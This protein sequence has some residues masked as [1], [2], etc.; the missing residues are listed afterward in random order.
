MQALSVLVAVEDLLQDA[1][2]VRWPA[3]Q[4]LRWL[5]EAQ[6]AIVSVRP[7]ACAKTAAVTLVAGELQTLPTDGLRLLDVIGNVGGRR[8]TLVSR[9]VMT[10]LTTSWSTAAS[11]VIKHY[12]HD[13]MLPREF[14]VFPSA[15]VGA[16]VLA[17]Y[18]ITPPE[19]TADTQSIALADN[20]KPALVDWICMRAF[21][22][23]TDTADMEKAMA[24]KS[25]FTLLVTGKGQAD[26]T[27]QPATS[28]PNRLKPNP[29]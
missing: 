8:I 16:Q 12:G 9:D 26:R 4:R 28:H 17:R 22:R 14:E 2:S 24:F 21:L 1:S 19:L 11:A 5:N 13:P 6:L 27:A 23:D 25:S 10:S 18:S 29:Q 3:A 15:I 7:D 20:W